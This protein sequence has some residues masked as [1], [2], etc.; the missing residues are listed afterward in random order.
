MSTIL[1]PPQQPAIDYPDSD[2]QPMADNTEQFKWIVTIEGGLEAIFRDRPNVFVAGDLLWYPVKGHPEIRLA[3]DALV[4]FGRPKGRRGS[5]RQ[6][7]EDN[8]APQV[9]FEVLSPGNWPAQMAQKL[10]F[11]EKYGVLEYYVYDPD[12]IELTGWQRVGNKLQEIAGIKGWTSP[13]LGVRFELSSGDLE[14]IGPD[15]R[16]FATYVE[17]VERAELEG[18]RAET[19]RQRAETERQRAETERQRA[20]TERQ[21][22]ESGHQRAEL[23]HE[24]AER[25]GE[26]LRE[27]GIDPAEL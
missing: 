14:I 22:A 1:N 11:Y 10:L 15:G 27:L 6:W 7:E 12:T 21:R 4:A 13:L 17:V 18:Q 16:P 8:I 23:E 5:Y 3:P 25:L 24:L 20:E 19:E 26:K 2:G 9:V